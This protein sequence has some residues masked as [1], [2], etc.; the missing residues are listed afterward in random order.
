M[1]AN[2]LL[3]YLDNK[4]SQEQETT[5]YNH[6]LGD[7]SVIL[8][9]LLDGLL[10]EQDAWDNRRWLDDSLLSDL[11]L[12]STYVEFGGITIWGLSDT[13]KQWTEPFQFMGFFN[14]DRSNFERYVFRFGDANKP[15]VLYSHFRL[16]RGIWDNTERD[17]EFEMVLNRK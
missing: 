14:S 17:W 5:Y 16:N 1:L 6:S 12:N 15:E 11:S 9:A 3:K 13:T 4:L 7:T 8:T 10:K 2:E